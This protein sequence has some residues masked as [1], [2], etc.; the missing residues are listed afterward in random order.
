MKDYGM[1]PH[2]SRQHAL[3]PTLRV[4]M[5]EQTKAT[6]ILRLPSTLS[7]FSEGKSQ[8]LLNAETIEQVFDALKQSFPQVWE[9]LCDEQGNVRRQFNIF[10]NNQLVTSLRDDAISLRSGQEIIV[11]PVLTST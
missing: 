4:D 9:K 6:V 10:V 2:T 3:K 7:A 8:L 1:Q 5:D 11:L